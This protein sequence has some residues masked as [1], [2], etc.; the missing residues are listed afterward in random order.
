[1]YQP[2]LPF[3]VIKEVM[4]ADADRTREELLSE[5]AT[6]REQS[7]RALEQS[8]MLWLTGELANIGYW[9]LDIITG[10]VRW[11]DTVF[12]IHG[13]SRDTYTPGLA[14]AIEFYHPED[15]EM[16]RA[17]VDAAV[18]KRE[19]FDFESR[20]IRKDGTVRVVK[21]Q[22][23][24]EFDE[25][26]K[27]YSVVGLFRD[28]T[29]DKS[30]EREIRRSNER[31]R[32]HV[33][34]TPLGM[35]EWNTEFR[36]VEW[37]ARCEE[38]FGYTKAE[39]LGRHAAELVIPPEAAALID[40]TFQSL[41]SQ[42]G[43]THSRNA[44]VNK[45]NERIVC[46][47]YNTPLVD[48]H[49]GVLGIAS[50]VQNV[51]ERHQLESQF[52]QSQ[53]MEAIGTLAGGIAHDMNNILAVVLGLGAIVEMELDK[54]SELRA[55]M[56]DILV[57]ARRGK[58]MVANLLGFA[59]KGRFERTVFP[60]SSRVQ[61]LVSLLQ[62]TIP[63]E[64]QCVAVCDDDLLHVR[65][66]ASQLMSA[67]MNLCLN[68]AQAIKGHGTI[69]VSA[70]N[71]TIDEQALGVRARLPRGPYVCL[72]VT[73]D[74][75]GMDAPTSKRAMEPFFTTKDVGEGTGLG[76]SMVYG[77]VESH[78][79]AVEIQSALGTG[80]TVSVFLPGHAVSPEVSK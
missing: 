55:D 22:G 9:S 31:L 35:L 63:R 75:C 6:L 70:S 62:K 49:G 12:A 41:M 24:P 65:G 11:S 52:A 45:A 73:D 43:G 29:D 66:D 1:M 38:I 16:V 32:A 17:H 47:W 69:T 10:T 25:E 77:A 56:Q 37:N 58:E 61:G 50:I 64:I 28:V 59:R 20:L 33:E 36:V 67:F 60:L 19:D 78:G 42:T 46:D 72:S 3:A 68:A 57:A 44:N 8:R 51:S 23:R 30:A 53:K 14:S 74:G 76:L 15:Q 34:N 21:S 18:S 40:D 80:T 79:G 48:R 54:G 5:L 39:A 4:K 7:R 27:L 2:D 13:L 71:T 26:G